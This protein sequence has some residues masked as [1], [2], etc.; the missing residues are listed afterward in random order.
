MELLAVALVL[1][2]G[3][4]V[5]AGGSVTPT[6]PSDG[7]VATAQAF[8]HAWEAQDSKQLEVLLTP[9]ARDVLAWGGGAVAWLTTR[10]AL[11]GPP[12]TGHGRVTPAAVVGD[13]ARMTV[14]AVFAC[15]RC[16]TPPPTWAPAPSYVSTVQLTLQR[17][18]DGR[19]LITYFQ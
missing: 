3:C 11:Y 1:L 13:T 14:A 6:P 18:P 9:D 15:A 7:P 10:S 17:Q 5:G 12:L 8:L 4:A 2:T 19:W 16:R